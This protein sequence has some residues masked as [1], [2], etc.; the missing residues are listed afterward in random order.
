MCMPWAKVPVLMWRGYWHGE[1]PCTKNL[2]VLWESPLKPEEGR[3]E[4]RSAPPSNRRA[5][6]FRL[7]QSRGDNG[8][9]H[10]QPP[11]PLVE[12]LCNL[13]LSEGAATQ[14]DELRAKHGPS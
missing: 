4:A 13:D 11:Q 14:L 1:P 6:R 12:K 10:E 3:K 7:P 8:P 5:W 9:Q 2:G